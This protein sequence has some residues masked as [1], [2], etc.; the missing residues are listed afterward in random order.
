MEDQTRKRGFK[1]FNVK[2]PVQ[3]KIIKNVSTH[4][5][6]NSPRRCRLKGSSE[7][8]GIGNQMGRFRS[9]FASAFPERVEKL[10]SL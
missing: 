2:L 10:N 5:K 9:D 6:D 7:I 3:Y 1:K 8:Y 4:I